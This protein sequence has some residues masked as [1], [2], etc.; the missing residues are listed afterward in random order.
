MATEV[1][2]SIKPLQEKYP[3]HQE[4]KKI[5]EN[6]DDRTLSRLY[7]DPSLTAEN[8]KNVVRKHYPDIE[9]DKTIYFYTN[10]FRPHLAQHDL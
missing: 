3:N 10:V 2:F 7:N 5:L 6:L 8:F 1:I 4:V 9:Q